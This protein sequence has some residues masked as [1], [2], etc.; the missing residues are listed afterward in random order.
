MVLQFT[1]DNID[2]AAS[3]FA[4]VF[5]QYKV[6]ALHGDMGAGKTTFVHALCK[7]LGVKDT[8][9]SPTFAII[10]EY[11]Y[12]NKSG[13]MYHIDLYRLNTDEDAVRAGVEDCFYSGNICLV[14]WPEKA[15]NIFPDNTL[16][17][18]VSA[19]SSDTRKISWNE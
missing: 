19:I 13:S 10:N 16:H 5:E 12:S 1:L 4:E 3:T 7:H 2:V 11:R 8:V 6:I 18:Y 15:P 14:E 9:S 17:I